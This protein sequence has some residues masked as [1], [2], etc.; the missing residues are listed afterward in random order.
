LTQIQQDI[1]SDKKGKHPDKHFR[2]QVEYNTSSDDHYEMPDLTVRSW[3]DLAERIGRKKLSTLEATESEPDEA[4]LD[5]SDDLQSSKTDDL[6]EQKKKAKVVKNHLWK[7]FVKRAF[8][9]T[10]PDDE[11]DQNFG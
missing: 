10:K 9:H 1:E 11:I 8:V 6:E 3:L 7:I 4:Q 2:Y 5:Q